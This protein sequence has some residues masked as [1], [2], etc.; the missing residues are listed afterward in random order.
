MRL[1]KMPSA[2]REAFCAIEVNDKAIELHGSIIA[3]AFR[4]AE[5]GAGIKPVRD[6]NAHL[7]YRTYQKLN[8]SGVMS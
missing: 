5:R 1:I 8:K 7:S 6:F 2:M 3:A 4:S